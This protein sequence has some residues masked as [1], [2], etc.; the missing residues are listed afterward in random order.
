[1]PSAAKKVKECSNLSA[2]ALLHLSDV[3][4]SLHA[5][6]VARADELASFFRAK[7]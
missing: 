3:H 2:E 7:P 1:M 4:R 6:L 5:L